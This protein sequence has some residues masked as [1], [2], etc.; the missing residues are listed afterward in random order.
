MAKG[1]VHDALLAS[2]HSVRGSMPSVVR[3]TAAI[4]PAPAGSTQGVPVVTASASSSAASTGANRFRRPL[5]ALATAALLGGLLTGVGAGTANASPP[6]RTTTMRYISPARCAANKAAGKITFV[7][8]F[9]YEATVGTIDPVAAQALGYYKDLCL[10]VAIQAGTG[11]PGPTAQATA[12]GTSTISELGGASDVVTTNANGIDTD[13]IAMYGNTNA[14]VLITMA[15][16]TSLKQLEGETLGYKGSMPP[17]ITAMLTKAGVDTAKVKEVGV[18]YDPTILPRGQVQALTGY[19]SNEVPT[20][21]G[22][23]YKIRTWDPGN[24]GIHGTFN[25]LVANP[26]FASAH[27]TAVEDFLRA[28]FKAFSYCQTDINPCLADLGKLTPTGFDKAS[29]LA[30]WKV[31]SKL[32]TSTFLPGR[33]IGAES[34][35]QYTPEYKLLL[36]DKLIP[37]SINLSKVVTPQYV[38]A[39]EHNGKLIWPAP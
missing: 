32:V 29:N 7:T 27:P 24:Y 6:A 11:D 18:G 25:A 16:T 37:K 17:Q 34:V 20:L 30:R 19:K 33:G 14:L 15:K 3:T 35:A 26:A 36:G 31:E 9:E 2:H 21:E 38:A 4:R 12:A 23:G 1:I 22:D 39:I 5:A 13:A 10:D 28:T 8:G